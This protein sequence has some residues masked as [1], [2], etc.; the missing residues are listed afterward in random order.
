MHAGGCDL[1]PGEQCLCDQPVV[2]LLVLRRDAALVGEPQ[3]DP[4]QAL[5]LGAQQLVR[6]PR[7]GPAAQ[8]EMRDAAL[9]VGAAQL[10]ADVCGGALCDGLRVGAGGQARH[11]RIAGRASTGRLASPSG[12]SIS[13]AASSAGR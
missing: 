6:A 12:A 7:R 2:A 3:L 5:R 4:V 13:R 11:E 1:R 10:A 9:L 8:G